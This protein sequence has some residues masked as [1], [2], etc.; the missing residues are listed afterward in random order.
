M[1]AT[2]LHDVHLTSQQFFEVLPQATQVQ[3]APTRLEVDKKVN[4]AVRFRLAPCCGP[5]DAHGNRSVRVRYAK[6]GLTIALE[7]T[8][9]I[10][11]RRHVPSAATIPTGSA[12]DGVGLAPRGDG[13]VRLHVLAF[14]AALNERAV[15]IRE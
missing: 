10:G 9:S 1:E 12:T 14:S 15:L 13:L 2:G 8:R 5:E 7:E 4:V 3:E 6:D 11:T